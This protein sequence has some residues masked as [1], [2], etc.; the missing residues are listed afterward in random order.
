MSAGEQIRNADALMRA[1]RTEE[2]KRAYMAAWPASK[3]LEPRQRVWL[4]ISIAYASIR[5]RDFDEA[6]KACAAAQKHYAQSTQIIAGNPLF[7]LLAGIAATEL[8][9]AAIAE[10]N[11]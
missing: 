10:D 4:L 5:A 8:N 11:L 9:E 2:A 3:E 7:H 1:G 6:F